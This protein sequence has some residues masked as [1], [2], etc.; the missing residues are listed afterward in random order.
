[1]VKIKDR[2]LP[3]LAEIYNSGGKDALYCFLQALFAES[4]KIKM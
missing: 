1:M 3:E 4:C 2:N